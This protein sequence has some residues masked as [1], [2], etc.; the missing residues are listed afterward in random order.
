[1]PTQ[2]PVVDCHAHVLDPVRI[3]FH[4]SGT[5]EIHPHEIGTAGQ[6]MAVLDSH[7]VSHALLINP[8][9][10]YGTDNRYMLEA[11]ANSGG[12]FKGVA[13]IPHDIS[14]A[15]LRAMDEAGVIGA[16]FSIHHPASP[17]PTGKEGARTLARLKEIGW[18]A[19]IHYTGDMLADVVDEIAASGVQLVLDHCGRPVVENGVGQPG[20]QA[21][22]RLGRAGKAIVK[23][24]GAFRF[25]REAWPHADVEP[26]VQALL[27]AFTPD[28][29]VWGSDWPFTR[30]ETRV[31]YGPLFMLM[32]RWVPDAA[33]RRK[34]LSTTPARL[35]KL[36]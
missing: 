16:R 22:L 26:F 1:M 8:L 3:P 20:F 9:G 5:Y 25:T 31:D 13:V 19:Q 17:M 6:Y 21:L 36:G 35:L 33:A 11:M 32:Q 15:E 14:D 28:R 23:L 18:F 2:D 27:E 12:R 7:G 4:P 24:S 10:G 30:M 34:I 29:C